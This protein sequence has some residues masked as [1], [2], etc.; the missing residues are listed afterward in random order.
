MLPGRLRPTTSCRTTRTSSTAQNQAELGFPRP[1][2]PFEYANAWGNNYSM[3]L[4]WFIL[5]GLRLRHRTSAGV[6]AVAVLGVS[7]IPVV[8]SQNRGMWLGLIIGVVYVGVRLAMR[9]RFGVLLGLVVHGCWC[10]RLVLLSPLQTVISKRI[11]TPHSN[12]VRGSLSLESIRVAGLSP[13]IGFGSTRSTIGSDK[14]LAIGQSAACPRC[15]NRVIGSTGQLWLLLV[16]QGFMGAIL[17]LLF[18]GQAVVRYWKDQSPVGM[19]GT[20]V[21]ILAMFYSLFYTAVVSPLAI[22]LL[23]LAMLWRNAAG[24]AGRPAPRAGCTGRQRGRSR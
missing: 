11:A 24:T 15:G 16:A 18:L 5:G 13:I 9:R 2:A 3:L 21:L 14:S 7:A 10:R 23:S 22:T 8:Y 6:V 19:A 20:F 1:S 12:D 4:V 17:Y